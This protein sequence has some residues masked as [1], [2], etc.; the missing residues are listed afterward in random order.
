MSVFLARLE[1]ART[2]TWLSIGEREDT[3]GHFGRSFDD[4]SDCLQCIESR[5]HSG[6]SKK[7]RK[8]IE[9]F[10]TF[11]YCCRIAVGPARA[12]QPPVP[13]STRQNDFPSTFDSYTRQEGAVKILLILMDEC[14]LLH[15]EYTR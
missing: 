11:S 1:F 15:V 10:C 3:N 7:L 9:N 4:T 13:A 2:E 12:D 5:K 8:T 14:E 6:C